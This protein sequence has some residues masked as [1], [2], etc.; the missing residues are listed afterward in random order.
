MSDY[1]EL[2]ISLQI[3]NNGA[4]RNTIICRFLPTKS[5]CLFYDVSFDKLKVGYRLEF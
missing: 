5:K 3:E 4:T 2:G 1:I